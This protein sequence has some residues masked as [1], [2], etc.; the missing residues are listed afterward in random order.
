MTHPGHLHCGHLKTNLTFPRKPA[1]NAG[2]LGPQ[3]AGSSLRPKQRQAEAQSFPRPSGGC[4][5]GPPGSGGA[6]LGLDEWKPLSEPGRW[7]P[8]AEACQGA[9]RGAG[10]RWRE[11][12]W[13]LGGQGRQPGQHPGDPARG[14][15]CDWSEAPKWIWSSHSPRTPASR[16]EHRPGEHP[17]TPILTPPAQGLT[18]PPTVTHHCARKGQALTKFCWF[19]RKR[20][21]WQS[22]EP[23]CGP[24]RG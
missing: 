22:W 8:G 24:R 15:H 3:R 13:P 23:R 9:G 7:G 5:L 1:A 17:D 10:T 20:R 11:G 19:C 2:S 6:A 14:E 12:R 18:P 16:A 4:R 21:R